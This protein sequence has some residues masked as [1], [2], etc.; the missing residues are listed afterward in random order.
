MTKAAVKDYFLTEVATHKLEIIR[1]DD[2]NRHIRFS[3]PGTR[4]C[5]FDLITWPGHLCVTGDCGTYVF[6]RLHDMF[7]F[8]RKDWRSDDISRNINTGYWAEKCIARDRDGI[9]EF[10]EDTFTRAVLGDLIS[11]IK[12]HREDTTQEERRELWDAVVDDVINADS[13]G[14]G[15]R[16]QIAAH[17]FVHK[18]SEDVGEFSFQD[19]WEHDTNKYTDRYLWNCYAIAWGI[20]QYDQHKAATAENEKKVA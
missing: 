6:E 5:M 20:R 1:D 13:D 19:F 12:S 15:H 7:K 2:V 11:W 18:V 9:T 4:D 8:F 14:G 10:C 16:Q 17:E 3:R